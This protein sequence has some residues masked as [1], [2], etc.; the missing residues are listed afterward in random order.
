MTTV[1]IE[2]P[3]NYIGRHRF[4]VVG[5]EYLVC[6]CHPDCWALVAADENPAGDVHGDGYEPRH[7]GVAK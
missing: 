7:A 1:F 6:P 3:A 5:D 4:Q 2:N